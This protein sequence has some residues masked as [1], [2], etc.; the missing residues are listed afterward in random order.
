MPEPYR[1]G[2]YRDGLAIIWYDTEGQRHRHA[3]GTN[4][5][6][7]AKL[8]APAWF[9]TLVRPAGTAVAALWHAYMN[10]KAGRASVPRHQPL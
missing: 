5:P 1:I 3:L 9:A 4:D 7:E 10:D 2:R 8:A 6:R